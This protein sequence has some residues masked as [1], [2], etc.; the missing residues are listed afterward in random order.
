M[1]LTTSELE[2]PGKYLHFRICLYEFLV[3][4]FVDRG[5]SAELK[6]NSIQAMSKMFRILG[7]MLLFFV[8]NVLCAAHDIAFDDQMIAL[9]AGN[10]VLLEMIQMTGTSCPSSVSCSPSRLCFSR[11]GS[12]RSRRPPCSGTTAGET[13][14]ETLIK[15]GVQQPTGLPGVSRTS[16]RIESQTGEVMKVLAFG[17]WKGHSIE[18]PDLS[19]QSEP[20]DAC[21]NNRHGDFRFCAERGG[22][23]GIDGKDGP[24]AL[25]HDHKSREVPWT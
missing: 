11:A 2:L 1:E 21:R 5:P 25:C 16:R 20:T 13:P 14:W 23:G 12:S 15:S 24:I 6:D 4:Y 10:S 9:L 22:I 8:T 18:I 7:A 17:I 3:P 19:G